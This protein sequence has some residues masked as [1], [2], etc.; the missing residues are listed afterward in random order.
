VKRGQREGQFK[1]QCLA[2][3]DEVGFDFR[4]Q[5]AVE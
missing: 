3:K 2:Y 4:P 1:V 5:L